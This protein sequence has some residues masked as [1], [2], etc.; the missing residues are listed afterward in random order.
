MFK[1]HS[2]Q[3]T[4]GKSEILF[5]TGHLAPRTESTIYAQMGETVVITMVSMNDRE[6]TLDY[7]PLSVEYIEKYY[8][9]G[10]IS[11]S[12]FLKRERRPTDEAVLKARQIDHSI[13]SLFPKGFKREV[14]VIVNVM[15]YDGEHDPEML[16][17][18]S[19]SMA[20]MNSSIPFNGPSASV[21]IGVRG[22]ELVV[23][24]TNTERKDLTA[25]FIVS[26]REDR[27][28]N[29][30]GS[31]EEV[32]E[33]TMGEILDLAVESC[34]PLLKVQTEFQ[35]E[36]GKEKMP[37]SELPV[38]E[39]LIKAIDADYHDRIEEGLYD[40]DKR[41]D[42]YAAIKEEYMAA[43][44]G[45]ENAFSAGQVYEA[46]D[47]VARKIMRKFVLSDEKRTSGRKLD[48]IRELEI[49]VGVLPRVHGSALFRRGMTQCLS[50][51]TLGSTRLAQTLESFEGEEEKSFMHHYNAPGYSLGEA[52]RFSYYPGRREI[53]H[54]HIGE[55][56]LEPMM[57]ASEVFPYTVRVVS[58]ILSQR[59]SSSMAATCG[60]SLALMD[61]G[62]PIKAPVGAISVGLV[63]AEGDLTTFKLLTDIEDVEDF[64]G[65]M[66]F[67]VAGTSKGVTSIQLDN[68]L[69]GVPVA[70]LKEAFAEAKKGREFVLEA[71][72]KVIDKARNDLSEYAPKVEVVR[73]NP[74]KIGELIGPGGKVIK[75]IMEKVN[76]EVDIDIQDDGQV[77][78][79]GVDKVKRELVVNMVKEMMMEPEIGK[80]YE[81]VVDKIMEYG[82]FVDVSGNI[83][84]LVHVSE[85]AEGFVKNPNDIVKEGQTVKV[86]II[87]IENGKISLS[88]KGLNT[89]EK[90]SVS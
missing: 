55:S 34:Q 45:E 84:G 43:H 12:R 41:S 79:T 89:P 3:V 9:G 37:F 11:G 60:S 44:A 32:P 72:N 81:G 28:L 53:G 78:I 57:P 59:G 87:K 20:L 67:K 85:M 42:I 70:I 10:I 24:P 56:A 68:K 6:S 19:A 39:E 47:Y 75:G 49:E 51:V 31:G 14:A 15:A 64:Y 46:I 80:I 30:E 82:A 77:N 61:A 1:T 33:E 17:V 76:N 73:I 8:A 52:G 65:D 16:A 36:V 7:F 69:M 58:E 83:S 13:R 23:N 38:A 66:D 4:L 22:E 40:V 5:K 29:I 90:A 74:A 21:V 62:V 50:I 27:V 26:V 86:K 88:M 25:E 2:K 35:K 54:G 63:T 18:V 48:E 71:M